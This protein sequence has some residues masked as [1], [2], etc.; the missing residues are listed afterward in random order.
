MSPKRKTSTAKF[1]LEIQAK[2]AAIRG[3]SPGVLPLFLIRVAT[4]S[5]LG[6]EAKIKSAQHEHTQT[7]LFDDPVGIQSGGFQFGVHAGTH[8]EGF[9]QLGPSKFGG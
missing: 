6:H 4:L 3:F 9:F 7:G 2:G 5:A 8:G 1:S